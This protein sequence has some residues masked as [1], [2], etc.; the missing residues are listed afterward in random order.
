MAFLKKYTWENYLFFGLLLLNALP[1]FMSSNFITLDGGAHAYNTN[2]ISQLLFDSKSIYHN[3]YEFNPEPVP[4]WFTHILLVV[5]KSVMPYFLAEKLVVLI[6]F[7]LTPLF[8]RKTILLINPNNRVLSYL[9]FPFTHFLMLYLGFFNFCYGI[10]FSFIGIYFWTKNFGEFNLKK[11]AIMFAICVATYFSHIF[12][13]VVLVMYCMSSLFCSYIKEHG[14]SFKSLLIKLWS[15]FLKPLTVFV[16]LLLPIL[17]LLKNYF[18]NRPTHGKEVF[19]EPMELTKMFYKIKPLQVYDDSELKYTKYIFLWI[20]LMAVVVGITVLI[21]YLKKRVSFR[22][23]FLKHNFLFLALVLTGLL[24]LVPDDD[25][26]GGFISLRIVLFIWYFFMFWFAVQNMNRIFQYVLVL[27]VLALQFPLL[28]KR[29]NGIKWTASNFRYIE[30][31]E[32]LIEPNSTVVQVFSDDGNWLGHHLSNYIGA[33]KPIVVL[34]NYEA[35]KEYFPLVW[36]DDYIPNLT[37]GKTDMFQTCIYWKTN[38]YNPETKP[39]D[40]VVMIGSKI[41]DECFEKTRE[42]LNKEGEITYSNEKVVL[43][44]IKK[45][46][47]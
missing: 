23:E 35:S 39:V 8:F 33:N 19:L 6:Y 22:A 30:K 25:G 37:I 18:A 17:Y 34:D 12:P 40:Y 2:I 28:M 24:F 43:Y 29:S 20:G 4:N 46:A 38:P 32:K 36:K 31:I 7:V 15:Y 42:L 16:I 3:Y 44:K 45:Q 1:L 11:W 41:G 14:S 10:M 47:K 5:F 13:F 26:Y 21:S 27:G 9:I